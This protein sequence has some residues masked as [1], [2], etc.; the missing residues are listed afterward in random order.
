LKHLTP[1]Q[2]ERCYLEIAQ[3]KHKSN[4]VN[5]NTLLIYP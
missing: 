1:Y 2:Y 5:K 3:E 4:N